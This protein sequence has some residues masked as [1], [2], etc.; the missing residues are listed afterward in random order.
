MIVTVYTPSNNVSPVVPHPYQ[1]LVL[2]PFFILASLVGMQLQ[3]IVVYPPNIWYFILFFP[4]FHSE[5]I[6]NLQ[7]TRLLQSIYAL[8]PYL[9][10][11][12]FP[13]LLYYLLPLCVCGYSVFLNISFCRPCPISHVMLQSVFAKNPLL[14]NHGTIL[15]SEK[16]NSHTV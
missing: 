1:R 10:A 14:N 6:S 3:N 4:T 7:A 11:V 12:H 5:I 13:C 8:R 2:S 15:K 16:F 9:P